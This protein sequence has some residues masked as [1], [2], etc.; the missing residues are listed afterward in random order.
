MQPDVDLDGRRATGSARLRR[1]LLAVRG[2]D[3]LGRPA[4]RTRGSTITARY[5]FDY[6]YQGA[7][8]WPFNTAYAAA[9]GLVSDVTQL[10]DLSEAEPF[11]KAGIPL[12]ASIAFSSNKLDGRSRA[13]TATSS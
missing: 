2:R 4:S 7:G 9:R 3:C 6:H 5:V 1:R 8:N 10:H 12:V 13:R 11:I